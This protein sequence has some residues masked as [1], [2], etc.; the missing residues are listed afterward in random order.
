MQCRDQRLR[1]LLAPRCCLGQWNLAW[2][3]LLRDKQQSQRKRVTDKCFPHRVQGLSSTGFVDHTRQSSEHVR[4]TTRSHHLEA[5]HCAAWQGEGR[6][7]D[8]GAGVAG[9]V[10]KP[11]APLCLCTVIPKGAKSTWV[12]RNCSRWL[13]SI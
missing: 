2:W 5:C 11:G 9:H 7:V 8:L 10:L 1:V 13:E 6:P 3:L 12:Y 4:C